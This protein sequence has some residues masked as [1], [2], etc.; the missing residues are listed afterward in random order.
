MREVVNAIF[1]LDRTGAQWRALPHD[2]PLVALV[3]HFAC[4]PCCSYS[5]G[6]QILFST[7]PVLHSLNLQYQ[8][9]KETV[10]TPDIPREDTGDAVVRG[11]NV[12]EDD[13]PTENGAKLTCTRTMLV[14][15]TG[16]CS[17][18]CH[19][20]PLSIS[21]LVN[22][23]SSQEGRFPSHHHSPHETIL[24]G[25]AS[26]SSPPASGVLSDW[27]CA[28][29]GMVKKKVVSLPGGLSTQIRPP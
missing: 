15:L 3:V 13:G 28:A 22:D 2:F 18:L 21:H 26:A 9:H 14:P 23:C 11:P 12:G 20:D 7:L 27:G 29:S 1:Y 10:K 8:E 24:R 4:F 6:E 25:C 5:I 16:F 17:F 19:N